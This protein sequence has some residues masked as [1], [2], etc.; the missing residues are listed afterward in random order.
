MVK[1]SCCGE[2]NREPDVIF[3]HNPNHSIQLAICKNCISNMH[4]HFEDMEQ[5]EEAFS[6]DRSLYKKSLK[7][8]LN[9]Y[10][11]YVDTCKEYENEPLPYGYAKSYAKSIRESIEENM[12]KDKG[13]IEEIFYRLTLCSLDKIYEENEYM[14]IPFDDWKIRLEETFDD[15]VDKALEASDAINSV[16][17]N[18]LNAREENAEIPNESKTDINSL[19]TIPTPS[20]IK[21]NLDRHI[22]G[23]EKAKK[24]VSVAIY[25]HLKRMKNNRYDIK[26][27]NIML[28][29]STGSGKTE[30]AR[31]IAEAIDAPF[32]IADCTGL[33]EAGY[34]GGDVEDILAKLINAA[35]GDIEKAQ[36]GV[37]YIDEIDKLARRESAGK[38]VSGEG[39][40]QAL[41]KILEGSEVT[42]TMGNKRSPFSESVTIDTTNILFICGGAFEGLTMAKK[43][44]KKALGF[45]A[46]DEEVDITQQ[47]IDAKA[48][49]KYGLTPEFVGRVPVIAILSTLTDKELKRILVEPENSLVKQYTE[50]I[51]LDNVKL[52]FTSSALEWIAKE[53]LENETGARGLQ[54]IIEEN[55]LDIMY[56]LPDDKD[57]VEVQ[58]GVKGGKLDFRKKG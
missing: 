38:D 9:M 3:L 19:N 40:Q 17:K 28:V 25:N 56:E 52:D 6:D 39:V 1:C 8:L 37:V 15:A 33:T 29:G 16:L 22:I 32:T 50:L 47:K 18:I 46:Q 11:E 41:L 12:G 35:G 10:I 26:K 21:K 49:V 23:Q 53:A 43:E 51:G 45:N 34:V 44:V 36:R 42:V 58:V 48:L 27:S 24:V 20:Q 2:V 55:M 14:D 30:I 7:G 5:K 54:T 31:H 57:V 13:R 4:K